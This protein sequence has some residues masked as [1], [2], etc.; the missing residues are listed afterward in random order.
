MQPVMK[1]LITLLK[2]EKYVDIISI[3]NDLESI[4]TRS[5]NSKGYKYRESSRI[6]K[7]RLGQS[8]H[9]I[10]REILYNCYVIYRQN[11]TL[12]PKINHQFK[13]EMYEEWKR[14]II[15][16]C[17]EILNKAIMNDN[18]RNA[19]Q[20]LK[21]HLKSNS[22][23][24][25]SQVSAVKSYISGA[26]DPEKHIFCEDI[27]KNEELMGYSVYSSL[28]G[29][30]FSISMRADRIPIGMSV[31]NTDGTVET[32]KIEDTFI[33]NTIALIKQNHDMIWS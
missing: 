12:P 33:S 8:L 1:Y 5:L 13:L 31:F 27:D 15:Q 14:I 30:N 18:L 3:L 21:A 2:N 26:F 16:E 28:D 23:K 19:V 10:F 32:A 25:A 24:L 29:I 20:E 6:N 22:L 17:D 7:K 11:G 4:F 9:D